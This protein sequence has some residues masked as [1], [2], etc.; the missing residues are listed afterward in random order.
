MQWWNN[1]LHWQSVFF[2]HVSFDQVWLVMAK[3][4]WDCADSLFWPVQMKGHWQW[5]MTAAL[6]H[7]KDLHPGVVKLNYQCYIQLNKWCLCQTN[8]SSDPFKFYCFTWCTLHLCLV[9]LYANKV[10]QINHILDSPIDQGW[11]VFECHT[12]NLEWQF[13]VATSEQS[14]Q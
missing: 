7:L 6:L 10:I 3:G 12:E 8:Y 5:V 2:Y 4:H 14:K 11:I 9:D 1:A 13:A